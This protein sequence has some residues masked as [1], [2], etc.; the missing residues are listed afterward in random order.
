MHVGGTIEKSL[1]AHRFDTPVEFRS[2]MLSKLG[3]KNGGLSYDSF[4]RKYTGGD[5]LWFFENKSEDA[6]YETKNGFV[7][8]RGGRI[9]EMVYL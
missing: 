3:P 5:E 8:L 7:L 9:V 2:E 6:A 1:L 4:I